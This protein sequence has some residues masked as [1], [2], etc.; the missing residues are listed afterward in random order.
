MQRGYKKSHKPH[1]LSFNKRLLKQEFDLIWILFFQPR[2]VIDSRGD[3]QCADQ[4]AEN[5]GDKSSRNWLQNS[6][7][8]SKIYSCRFFISYETWDINLQVYIWNNKS[9]HK[10]HTMTYSYKN[11]GSNVL[12]SRF[13]VYK[14]T[15][16]ILYT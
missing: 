4:C 1:D 3:N 2:T 9:I 12:F 10:V 16:N 15:W 14:R 11:V 13:R 7:I 6:E 8:N 5:T